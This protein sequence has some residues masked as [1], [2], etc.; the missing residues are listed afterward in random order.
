LVLDLPPSE[1][2]DSGEPRLVCSYRIIFNGFAAG[3]M[4][5]ELDA[6]SKMPG[7]GRW[8]PERKLYRQTTRTSRF[9]GRTRGAS[10]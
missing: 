9:L 2:I 10:F 4:K 5:A 7:F 8:F 1:I 3:F 6:M